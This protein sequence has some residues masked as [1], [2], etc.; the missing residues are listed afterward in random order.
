MSKKRVFWLVKQVF[1]HL[2]DKLRNKN[3]AITQVGDLN[4]EW[5]DGN[6][7]RQIKLFKNGRQISGTPW[8]VNVQEI[9]FSTIPKN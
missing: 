1:N 6:K 9:V 8:N 2:K 5:L 4:K 7:H 3:Q